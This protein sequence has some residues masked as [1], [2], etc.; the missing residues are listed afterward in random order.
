[1]KKSVYVLGFIAAFILSTSFL[2]KMM[3]WPF[4]NILMF[5]GFIILN[6]GFLPTLFFKLYKQ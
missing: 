3:H 6:L 5:T 1:M 2:F 4:A